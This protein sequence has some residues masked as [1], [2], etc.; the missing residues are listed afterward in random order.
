MAVLNDIVP[1]GDEDEGF[2]VGPYLN[3]VAVT[4]RPKYWGYRTPEALEKS[5]RHVKACLQDT[6]LPWLVT[7]R[8]PKVFAESVDDTAALAGAVAHEKAGN[9]GRARDRY[10]EMHRRYSLCI[11]ELGE[12][13]TLRKSGKAVVFVCAKLGVDEELRMRFED[14]LEYH[15]DIQPI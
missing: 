14:K 12:N 15:P 7:L 8:D 4:S 13:L 3:P 9:L 6:G 2:L 11:S 1:L 5:L 10:A